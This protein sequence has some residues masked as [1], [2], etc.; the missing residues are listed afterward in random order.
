MG[1]GYAFSLWNDMIEMYDRNDGSRKVMS[2]QKI[3]TLT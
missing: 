1:H 3:N 2:F